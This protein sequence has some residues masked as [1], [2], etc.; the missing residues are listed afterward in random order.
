MGAVLTFNT[1]LENSADI[2]KYVTFIVRFLLPLLS[3]FIILRCAKSLFAGSQENEIWGYLSLDDGKRIPLNHFEN[4]I[5]RA[6]GSD[7]CIDYSTMSRKHAALIRSGKGN[8][9]LYDLSSKNGVLLN[10]EKII[11]SAPVAEGDRIELGGIEFTFIPVSEE[12]ERIQAQSRTKPG[13]YYNP[14]TTMF[15]LTEF[16][17]LL[18]AQHWIARGSELNIA[19]PICFGSFIIITWCYYFFMRTIKR[20]GFEIEIIAFYLCSLGMSVVATSSPD[21]LYK[22]MAFLIIGLLGFICLGWFLRDINRIKLLRRPLAIAGIFL[23]AVNILF[24]G[25]LFGARNWL[26]IG[27]FSLQPSEF[28][29]ICF[30]FA[31]AATLDK[32]FTKKNIFWFI[33]FSG[34]CVVA[35]VLMSDFGS[36]AV[37]FIAYLVIAYLRSGD[38]ATI[39]LSAGGAAFA[40]I[41]AV[42]IKPYIAARFS[43]WLH[44]WEYASEGGY[45]QTRTMIAA[46]SGGLFGVGAGEG[47]LHTVFAADTDMVFGMICEELGL[48]IGLIAAASF[49]VLAIFIIRS[50]STARSSFYVIGAC[51]AITMMLFQ[52]TL[53]VF[54]AFDILP[55][56]GVT[57]PFISKGG[58]SL[59]S[60]WCLL[61]FIKAADT[62]QNA[63]FA[64][65]LPKR[66]SGSRIDNEEE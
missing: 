15:F 13:G 31:G 2:F 43:T 66:R 64:V 54:G 10:G 25:T 32:L 4:T 1:L 63:S 49:I 65:R 18:C 20:L 45:Q 28:V 46:A 41:I 8:W 12:D 19:I 56:T 55:F 26:S 11:G 60:C 53:N 14:G 61:A 37:F 9:T 17:L 6:K 48:V 33:G 40:G 52:I 34:V 16:Q 50:S 7:V 42:S 24:A 35:L 44:A 39:F 38:F 27:G 59:I 58:S 30:V 36:A 21:S 5:G 62:R 57:F 23:L 22:Q 29:K 3:L 51:G 47:W